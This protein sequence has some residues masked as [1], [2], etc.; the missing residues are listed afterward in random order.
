MPKNCSKD[1][2]LVVDYLDDFLPKANASAKTA[3][4]KRFGLETLEHDDDFMG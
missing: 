2:S 3:M 4:K 1:V